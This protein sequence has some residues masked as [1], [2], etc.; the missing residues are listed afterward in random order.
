MDNKAR[1]TSGDT[2]KTAEGRQSN[3]VVV[4][5]SAGGVEA[6]S[7]LVSSLPP[8]FPA[9]IVLAQHLD[10]S[11]PSSLDTILQRR[12]T[13]PVVVVTDS[14]ALEPGKIYVV[15]S[16]HHVSINDHRVEVQEDRSKRP[17]PS[18]D[19]LLSTAAVA[20]GERLIA[21]ILTGS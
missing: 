9:P 21:A 4:G 11:R 2:S 19:T 6:L 3:L 10:P 5:S 8:D 20:Y 14:S 17:R 13:L 18:V 1:N 7:I 12:T 16:N 15:P